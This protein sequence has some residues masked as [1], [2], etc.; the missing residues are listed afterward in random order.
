MWRILGIND[1]VTTCECCGKS[2]LKCTVVLTNGE[3][4]VRYGRQCAAHAVH[5]NKKASSVKQIDAA[6]QAASLARKWLQA[7][8]KTVDVAKGIWNRFGFRTGAVDGGVDIDGVGI[9]AA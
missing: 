6:S 4:E 7:G 2:G 1:E 8:H 5:G 3:S 9:I